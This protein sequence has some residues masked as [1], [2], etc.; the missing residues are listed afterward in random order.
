MLK[1]VSSYLALSYLALAGLTVAGL[2]QV[3]AAW[4][5]I[6][7]LALLDYRRRPAWRWAL[8]PLLIAGAY[9]WFFGTRRGI[10]TP[11][12]AGAELTV[13]F[14]G[15]TLL[16]LG[17][18]LGAASLLRPYR[19]RAVPIAEGIEPREV[20]LE[21]GRQALLF[22]SGRQGG[23]VPGLCLLGDPA[24]DVARLYPLA[25]ALAGQGS[26]V[27]L[28][29]WGPDALKPGAALG[30]VTA[31]LDRLGREPAVDSSRLALVGANLGADLALAAAAGD[32]RVRTVVALAPEI[33][34]Q[35]ARAGLGLLQEMTYAEAVRWRLR[36]RRGRALRG[37]GAFEAAGRLGARPALT[38]YGAQ[39]GVVSLPEA[40]ARLVGANPALQFVLVPG[41]GHVSLAT[42]RAASAIVWRWLAE[43]MA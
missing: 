6:V 35:S 19:G 38:V 33:D 41:E 27:L 30:L 28:P 32:Q 26:V 3:L 21:P 4:R 39:E 2:L 23:P 9:A 1:F 40:Q 36:G 15:A 25:S 12:P 16:A 14:G 5:S 29:V 22:T 24:M 31:G 42:S 18:T 11:G 8:G 43:H 20:E 13:L 10:L 37:L 17:V 7:G 34:E